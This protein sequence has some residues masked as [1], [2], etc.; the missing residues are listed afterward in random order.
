MAGRAAEEIVFGADAVTAGASGDI[1]QATRIVRKMLTEWGMDD[2]L[3][4]VRLTE[5]D[6]RS[7]EP[8]PLGEETRRLIDRRVKTRI[9]EAYDE[10]K[11][12]LLA[13]RG[14]LDQLSHMLLEHETVSGEEI[15]ALVRHRPA[16]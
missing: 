2:E 13:R 8:V 11:A 6:P 4:M 1:D 7:G 16:A 10:A 9:D 14:L 5:A 15:M 3:G 12:M